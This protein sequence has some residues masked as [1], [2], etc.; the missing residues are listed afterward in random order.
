MITED[1]LSNIQI[2]SM[3]YDPGDYPEFADTYISVAYWID[4]GKE[5]TEDELEYLDENYSDW[6][7]ECLMDY[8]Y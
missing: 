8:L 7:Y 1:Q 4:T 3:E 5:L 2:D 6:V